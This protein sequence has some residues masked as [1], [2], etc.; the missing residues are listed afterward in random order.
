MNEYGYVGVFQM[1]ETA[2]QDTGYYRG[3][4]T[5]AND[6]SGS[7]TGRDGINSLA[8]FY[9][10]PDVQVKAVVAYHNTLISQIQRLGLDR[11]IGTIVGGVPVTM[12]GLVAGAHLVGA[13]SL[14]RFINSSGATVPKDGNNVAVTQYMTRFG[15]CD[16]DSTAPSFAA[17]AAAGG[18]ASDLTPTPITA[19][20]TGPLPRPV[21]IALD[22]DSAFA[23]ASGRRPA[24]V[25]EAITAIVATLLT[26]WLAW[27]TQ[28]IFFAWWRGR[29]SFFAMKAEIIRGCI[30]L[31]VVLVILQ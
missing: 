20:T 13:R 27:T 3:D 29:I 9:A 14:Q 15:G 10:H 16:F 18:G 21:R 11:S 1:G 31:C 5:R 22:P 17:V 23:M 12:S 26:L 4:S 2:L 24:E 8:D 25:R 28:A 6:W 7:W 19:P 30:M